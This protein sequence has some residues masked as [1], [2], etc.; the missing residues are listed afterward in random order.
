MEHTELVQELQH[1]EKLPLAD[2]IK[3]NQKR[4]KLQLAAYAKWTKSDTFSN[5]PRPKN[6]Q[7]IAFSP[8]IQ[9]M[10]IAA[11]GA[12]DEMKSLLKAGMMQLNNLICWEVYYTY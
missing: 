3:L 11:R 9:L 8:D 1:I 10:D 7:G 4:R 12:S 2:R 5:R 6:R